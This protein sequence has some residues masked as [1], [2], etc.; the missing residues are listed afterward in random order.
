MRATVRS[1]LAL[2][3]CALSG[4][5]VFDALRG[6][7]AET[8]VACQGVALMPVVVSPQASDSTRAVAAELAQYLSQMTGG[9][10]TVTTGDS[11]R[12]IVLGSVADFPAENTGRSAR[13]LELRKTYD[14]KEAYLIRTEPERV[15]LLG[16]TDLGASHAAFRFL[17][18]LGCRWLFPAKEWEVVPSRPTVRVALDVADRPAI[19]ARRIWYGWGFFDRA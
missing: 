6:G 2:A 11:S 3:A 4:C 19:L 7:P 13:A 9:E 15:L 10:F 12:G 18:K 17:E 5:G 1:L 16:A 14:G 8:L